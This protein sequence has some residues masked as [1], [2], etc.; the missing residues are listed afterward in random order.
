MNVKIRL[1]NVSK[2]YGDKD[3]HVLN[4]INLNIYEGE[5]FV[6]VGPS[7]S[8]KSTILRMIAGLEIITEGNILIDDK[9]INA[10]PTQQRNLSMVFQNYALYPHM[11][12]EKNILF[13]LQSRKIKRFD[14]QSRMM[15]AVN[16][17][18]I[19]KLL[20]RKPK[21]LSGGQKQRVALAR[22]VVS[23][24]PI[25][26]MDEPLSNLDMQLRTNMRREIKLL[27]QRLGL[28][29]V[30]VTHDQTEAM[31]MGDRICVLHDG[32]IQQI[33]T[34]I[35]IYN[36][37]KN[38]FVGEF[39]GIP[40]MNTS[41]AKNIES[42]LNISVEELFGKTKVIVGIRPEHVKPGN[43]LSV[44]VESIEQLGVD[45]LLSFN[46][47]DDVWY[48]KWPGQ[49]EIST[50]SVVGIQI[51]ISKLNYFDKESGELL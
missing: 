45:T 17:L 44:T 2:R 5:F 26:L 48:A 4:N 24:M 43:M 11:T 16:I 35:N 31:T 33:D 13:G 50:G 37:P 39:I 27:Q 9:I 22:A 46:F 25:C 42:K 19:E 32:E 14:Q 38:K 10:V 12:V 47:G 29:M 8:G 21:Q 7:G 36:H 18:G 28:T 40:K 15:E 1:N 49:H 30:Y 3:E 51:N 20:Q 6:L 41:S 34:P 23:H